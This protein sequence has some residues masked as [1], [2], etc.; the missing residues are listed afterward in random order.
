MHIRAVLQ[1]NQLY[2]VAKCDIQQGAKGVSEFTGHALRCIAEKTGEWDDG[3]GVHGEFDDRRGAGDL[4]YNDADGYK[5]QHYV[6]L[7]VE[8]DLLEGQEESNCNVPLRLLAA[9]ADYD[10]PLS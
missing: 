9:F 1:D 5:D 7:A 4:L 3:Q 10:R 8:H 6:E 2:C